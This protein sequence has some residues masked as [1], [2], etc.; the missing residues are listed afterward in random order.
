LHLHSDGAGQPVNVAVNALA[1]DVH[2]AKQGEDSFVEISVD[3]ELLEGAAMVDV[4]GE[5]LRELFA[6]ITG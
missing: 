2:F 6:S 4:A 5:D 1:G 3:N